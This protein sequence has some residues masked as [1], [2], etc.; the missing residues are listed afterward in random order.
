MYL[1]AFTDKLNLNK[2]DNDCQRLRQS[3]YLS[4]NENKQ[5]NA[6]MQQL[7]NEIGEL[8]INQQRLNEL[9]TKFEDKVIK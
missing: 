1:S 5:L 8:R 4:N 2:K 7:H 6:Q 9:Q 3:L